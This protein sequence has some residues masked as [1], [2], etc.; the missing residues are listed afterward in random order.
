MMFRIA[1]RSIFRNMRRSL[2]TAL[3]IAVGMAAM[4]VFAAYALYDTTILQTTAV[5]RGGHLT[6]FADGYS[7]FGSGDP[8]I[9]GIPDYARVVRLIRNDAVMARLSAV[10]TPVQ[11]LGGIAENPENGGS[12]TFF[13][14]G[15][16]PADQARMQTWDEYGIGE[17]LENTG[18]D[19]DNPSRGVIGL[20]LARYLGLCG[21]LHLADCPSSP[22]A[23]RVRGNG[24]VTSLPRQDFSALAEPRA[25][26]AAAP[27]IDLIA[28]TS[29]GAPNIVSLQI[30]RVEKQGAKEMDDGYV[31]MNLALAQQLVYG[32]GEHDVTGIIVQL[33]RTEDIPLV[34]TRLAALFAGS[35]LALEI[36][37]F[38][39]I[40]T[41]YDQTL[42]FF[43]SLFSFI[44]V[45]IGVVVLFTVSNT[46][47][48]SV[49]E[50]I[51]EIGTTRA[52]GARR[53]R[54][55]IQFLA[56]G[57]MLGFFGAVLGIAFAC[58]ADL[59]INH[60]GLSWTPPGDAHAIP[61]KLYMLGASGVIAG[62]FA[63]LV[64]VA[65]MA[66][67]VPANRAARLAIVDAL[68]HA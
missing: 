33:H 19:T 34:R 30:D 61:L 31:V 26:R 12:R 3:T 15:F 62:T 24:D 9:W 45:L 40:N 58:A 53:G 10:V 27:H 59:A 6:V 28:A 36:R 32:R 41:Y 66:A 35:R 56:E 8:A 21:E 29:G 47:G 42:D 4:L 23:L 38:R 1:L 11:F 46:M 67:L 5:E 54:I 52:L 43:R 65:I 51:D 44:A 64:A 49:M 18:L 55:R 25:S 7:D 37:D 63:V 14:S 16:V 50:R 13:A 2:T 39:Q 57:A 17:A 68:R 22:K 20:G 48:M 60:A